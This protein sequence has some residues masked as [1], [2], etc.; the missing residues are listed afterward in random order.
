MNQPILGPL[1]RDGPVN[2]NLTGPL[3]VTLANRLAD[4]ATGIV[5]TTWIDAD[6]TPNA[7][8]STII[9]N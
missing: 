7:N 3:G 8:A 6:G 4:P 9:N 5:L 2:Q 1:R